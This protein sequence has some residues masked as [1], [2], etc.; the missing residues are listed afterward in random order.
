VHKLHRTTVP[1]PVCLS[2]GTEGRS[3]GDLYAAE[4]EEIRATLLRLQGD[5]CAYCER[6]TG[7]ERNDGHIE[8]FRDQA[9]HDHLDLNWENL[10]W[11]CS[12]ENTC[13]K[14]KDK[15]KGK[16]GPQ[17]T[18]RREE[19]LDPSMDD[20]ELFLLFLPDG[21]V[22][23]RPDL[24]PVDQRRAEETLRVFQLDKSADLRRSRADAV[25]PYVHT[26]E[27]LSLQGPEMLLSYIRLTLG[28]LQT[29]PFATAIKQFLEGMT[30]P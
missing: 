3:Y 22:R 24:S 10:F 15:C 13:G 4:K 5:R 6:R 17:A 27:W 12:D 20:P 21:T 30:S 1:V 18:F 29:T 23:P 9:G 11:S 2:E 7:R 16:S 28:Q 26:L 25:K 14:H 8:H 19:I